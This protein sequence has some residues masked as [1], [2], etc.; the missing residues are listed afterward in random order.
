MDFIV[1]DRQGSTVLPFLEKQVMQVVPT[2][3]VVW[4][5]SSTVFPCISGQCIREY[6]ADL[7]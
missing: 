2:G 5:R 7:A 6:V 3:A 4:R 1:L